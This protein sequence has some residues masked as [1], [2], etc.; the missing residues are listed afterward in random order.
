MTFRLVFL[1]LPM[2][3]TGKSLAQ[4]SFVYDDKFLM[5]IRLL[6]QGS[7]DVGAFDHLGGAVVHHIDGSKFYC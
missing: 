6:N 3:W 4:G 7:L 5:R 1:F 2:I